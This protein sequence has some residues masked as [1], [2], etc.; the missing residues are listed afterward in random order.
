LE[1]A[2]EAPS[3]ASPNSEIEAAKP[4]LGKAAGARSGTPLGVD[5]FRGLAR[6]FSEALLL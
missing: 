2:V 1:G 3:K 4:A 5:Q 6:R